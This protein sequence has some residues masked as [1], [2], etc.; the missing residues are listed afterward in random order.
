MPKKL[1]DLTPELYLKYKRT[2]LRDDQIARLYGCSQET[3]VQ[4]KR[5]N[6][7]VGVNI[8]SWSIREKYF[9][10]EIEKMK[11]KFIRLYKKGWKREA[12]AEELGMSRQT[13]TRFVLKYLPHMKAYDVKVKLT[14]EQKQIIQ[15][16]GLR[17]DTVRH[18][19]YAGWPIE[20]ALTEPIQRKRKD[21]S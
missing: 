21:V 13:L 8:Q 14:K 20:R 15:K 1:D 3:L 12:I 9:P 4:W 2:K 10:E 7:L 18:R 5:K 6:G 17:I 19:I 11:K 16:H